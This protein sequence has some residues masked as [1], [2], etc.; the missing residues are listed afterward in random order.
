MM[1]DFYAIPYPISQNPGV[2]HPQRS[3]T[4][5][6]RHQVA[7]PCKADKLSVGGF[8]WAAYLYD[9]EACVSL[10]TYTTTNRCDNLMYIR[11]HPIPT[12]IKR[13]SPLYCDRELCDNTWGGE[14]TLVEL[15][16][17][18]EPEQEHTTHTPSP[19][20]TTHPPSP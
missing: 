14:Q 8:R 16:L 4:A 17:T 7:D 3:R 10:H 1:P 6:Y 20:R 9:G 11:Q 2:K 15:G 13:D 12:L 19:S 5:E 18:S